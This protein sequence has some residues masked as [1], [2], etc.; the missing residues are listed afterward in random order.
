MINKKE[1]VINFTNPS[2]ADLPL[3]FLENGYEIIR[4][5]LLRIFEKLKKESNSFC[6]FLEDV[7]NISHPNRMGHVKRLERIGRFI[8]SGNLECP[9]FKLHGDDTLEIIQGQHRIIML[10]ELYEEGEIS[11]IISIAVPS[12]QATD[13]VSFQGI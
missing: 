12:H 7:C 3:S 2:D 5:D 4:V 6:Y 11:N 8:H 1:L 13:F 10:K 9:V